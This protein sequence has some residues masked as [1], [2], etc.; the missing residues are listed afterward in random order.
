MHACLREDATKLARMLLDTNLIS[1]VE[2]SSNNVPYLD[3]G[4]AS[5]FLVSEA[6]PPN[7]GQSLNTHFLWRGAA[8]P[9]LQVCRENLLCLYAVNNTCVMHAWCTGTTQ[10]SRD[11]RELILSLYERHLSVDGRAVDYKQL[12]K[13]EMFK[14]YVDTA[15]ELQ[16]VNGSK[17]YPLS[18]ACCIGQRRIDGGDVSSDGP[19]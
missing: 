3:S 17:E 2:L 11:L 4:D 7:P 16:K 9:A 6:P 10:V 15:A 5:Y 1:P 8:R 19:T 14:R 13:D 12:G 18:I